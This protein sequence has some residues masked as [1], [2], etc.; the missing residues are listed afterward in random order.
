MKKIEA[1]VKREKME[2]VKAALNKLNVN[3]MTIYQVMGCGN[4]K[5]WTEEG[6]EDLNILPKVKFDI[7]ID[8]KMAEKVIDAISEAAY[9]GDI[10]DGKIFICSVEQAIR[11]R[12][13]E[14]GNDAL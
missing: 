7:V 1:I 9:T 4:Q 3:G 12:T 6:M 8:D 13:K 11:I 5:G 10:G 2:D 14:R